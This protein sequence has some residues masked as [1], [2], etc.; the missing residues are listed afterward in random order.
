VLW[1][2]LRISLALSGRLTRLKESLAHHHPDT[3]DDTAL[4][5][6]AVAAVIA[7][8]PDSILL[9]RRADRLGDPWSGHMALPGG[10]R[11]PADQDLLATAIRET[12][13]EVGLA[14]AR[15]DLLGSINDVVPRTPVLPPVA[16]RPFVF[17]TASRSSLLLS[18]EVA[19]ATW[20]TI[21]DLLRPDR[22]GIVNLEVA[23]ET[24]QFPAY[25][26]EGGIVWGMTERILSILLG[27]L[28]G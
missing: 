14:L 18:S 21:D 16:V 23:G 6:A 7:P 1:R 28:Q 26:L 5:W 15:S 20:V 3:T 25:Q 12:G 17:L 13:E 19:E 11:E 2:W 8:D 10:R 4:I 9:I 22:H 24:R 27:H